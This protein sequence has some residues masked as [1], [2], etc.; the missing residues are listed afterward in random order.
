MRRPQP[1]LATTAASRRTSSFLESSAESSSGY[2]VLT[3]YS[4]DC[5]V[6]LC[7]AAG[8]CGCTRHLWECTRYLHTRHLASSKHA[9]Q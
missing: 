6:L 9:I 8:S 2:S 4:S 5:S 1:C 3:H 7:S